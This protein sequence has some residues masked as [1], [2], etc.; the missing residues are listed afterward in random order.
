MAQWILGYSGLTHDTKVQ[1]VEASLRHAITAYSAAAE[2]DRDRKS[3]AVLHLAK[4]LLAARSKALRAR[5]SQFSEPGPKR[6]SEE[7][8]QSLR[9]RKRELDA[10][11]VNGILREF[12]FHGTQET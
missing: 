9:T 1:D 11:G 2:A 6:A 7:H 12:G 10:Q 4:R 8:V 3:K 5:I